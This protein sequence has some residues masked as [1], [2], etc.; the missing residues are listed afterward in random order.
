MNKK[1]FI[2]T[3]VI[4][5]AVLTGVFLQKRELMKMPSFAEEQIQM[6]PQ[7]PFDDE[8]RRFEFGKI[9]EECTDIEAICAVNKAV[10]C[11]IDP[12]LE[13]CDK[14]YVPRFIFIDDSTVGRPEY[15]E[16]KVVNTNSI[17]M[18]TVEIQTVGDCDGMWFGL[19]KGNIIYVL[20]DH[21]GEWV[22]K[23]IYALETY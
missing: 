4:M 20:T 3:I 12:K 1:L 6:P 14:N 18:N 5:L 17:D 16:Y 7:I 23:D 8:T 10:K 2:I 21:S 9:S 22:V 13:F 19:C 11:T 15:I